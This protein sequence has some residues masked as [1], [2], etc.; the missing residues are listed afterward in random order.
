M[1]REEL[2][3]SVWYERLLDADLQITIKDGL[4]KR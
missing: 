1:K 3:A 2:N 4:K